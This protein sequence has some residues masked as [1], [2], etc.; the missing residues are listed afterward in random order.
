MKAKLVHL[1]ERQIEG[2][3]NEAKRLGISVSELIRRVLDEHLGPVNMQ[4]SQAE[5]P[6]SS[7]VEARQVDDG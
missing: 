3:T 5:S 1:T 7:R 4:W 2:L 6:S